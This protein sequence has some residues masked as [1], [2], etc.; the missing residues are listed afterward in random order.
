M[1]GAIAGLPFLRWTELGVVSEFS[2]SRV[3]DKLQA[4]YQL[5]T[6]VELDLMEYKQHAS[7]LIPKEPGEALAG[8][9]NL[10]SPLSLTPKE[11]PWHAAGACF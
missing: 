6:A 3:P 7:L 4:W 2:A 5:A 11:S 10:G 1:A 8:T 9:E